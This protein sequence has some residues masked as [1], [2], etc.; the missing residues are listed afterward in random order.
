MSM[1]KLPVILLVYF[2]AHNL[3]QAVL[4]FKSFI[5]RNSPKTFM[6]DD[7]HYVGNLNGESRKIPLS[8]VAKRALLSPIRGPESP[9]RARDSPRRALDSPRLRA[10]NSPRAPSS[11][12]SVRTILTSATKDPNSIPPSPSM[13]K[14]HNITIRWIH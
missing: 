3:Y 8:P 5:F 4:L 2:K 9:I 6:L 1:Y 13:P 14:I 10:L 7:F 12:P 11:S